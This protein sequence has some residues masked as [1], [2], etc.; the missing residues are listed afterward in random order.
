MK[1]WITAIA[2]LMAISLTACTGDPSRAEP[3]PDPAKSG[4][5]AAI[6]TGNDAP[7]DPGALGPPT[8]A[9]AGKEQAQVTP[10]TTSVLV[11]YYSRTGNTREIADQIRARTGG[12]LFELVPATPYP[13]D[14]DAC[15]EQAKRELEAGIRPKLKSRISNLR[16]YDV[17]FIG[18][19]NWWG[20]FPGPVLTFL[21]ENDLSGKTLVPF[22][23]HEGSGLGRSVRD[24]AKLCPRSTLLEGLAVRGSYVKDAQA[25]VAKWLSKIGMKE[26]K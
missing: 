23:T 8:P 14:Y 6:G 10:R 2:M 12:E 26:K 21:T 7:A 25:E 24:I 13:D 19:P 5:T 18:Y 16:A 22:C 11:A 15:V 17:I 9:S 3:G 20:T 1:S 4:T